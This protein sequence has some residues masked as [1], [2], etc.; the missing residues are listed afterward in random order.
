MIARRATDA[1]AYA[2]GSRHEGLRPRM[3]NHRILESLGDR[4]RS[5]ASRRFARR[6]GANQAP[7]SRPASLGP[8]PFQPSPTVA[9]LRTLSTLV[10]RPSPPPAHRPKTPA[11]H[12]SRQ[13]WSASEAPWTATRSIHI[14]SARRT[15]VSLSPQP[16]FRLTPSRSRS[17]PPPRPG[18][19]PV[20]HPPKEW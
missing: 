19:F 11:G 9:R 20:V 2:H 10:R 18:H 3:P 14:A 15:P 1:L 8:G 5:R 16:H 4:K 7:P 12:R 13:A 17:C 6:G